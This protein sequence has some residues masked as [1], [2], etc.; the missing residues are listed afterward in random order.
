MELTKNLIELRSRVQARVGD[1]ERYFYRLGVK[2]GKV[3]GRACDCPWWANALERQAYE[4][5]FIAGKK[6]E[7]QTDAYWK[8]GV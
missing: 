5:G 7:A 3:R 8:E 2:D 1:L 6:K 4:N